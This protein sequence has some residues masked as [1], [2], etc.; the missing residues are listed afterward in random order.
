MGVLQR[1]PHGVKQLSA[2][3]ASSLLCNCLEG[4]CVSA[5]SNG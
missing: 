2:S 1:M 5:D 3:R 4:S